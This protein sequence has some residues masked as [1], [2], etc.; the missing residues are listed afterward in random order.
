ML[1]LPA[2]GDD[3][4]PLARAQRNAVSAATGL[5]LRL[6]RLLG[7]DAPAGHGPDADVLLVVGGCRWVRQPFTVGDVVL[8]RLPADRLVAVR[9]GRLMRHEAVHAEQWARL[10]PVRFLG[11]YLLAAT[12]SWLRTGSPAC[13]NRFEVEAGL[14]DGGYRC[15]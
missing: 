10:G 15:R 1:G 6:G 3:G 12:W 8:T 13:A 7:G 2:V 4:L 5:A 11:A 9:D 14:A